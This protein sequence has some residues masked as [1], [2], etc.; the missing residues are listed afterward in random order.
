MPIGNIAVS[1]IVI[2]DQKNEFSFV[3]WLE[4]IVFGYILLLTQRSKGLAP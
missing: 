4:D 3:Q 1:T 2:K